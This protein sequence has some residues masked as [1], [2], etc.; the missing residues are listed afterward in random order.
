VYGNDRSSM[1]KVFF[2]AWD[3]YRQSLPLEGIEQRLIEIILQHPEYHTVLE[4]RERYLDHDWSPEQGETNPFMHMSM[5]VSIEEQLATNSPRGIGEHYQR[6]LNSEG[7]RH[8][9]MHSMMDCLAEAIWK[10]QR[11][12]TTNLEETYLECLEKTGQK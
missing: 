1:R 4:N 5:H 11:Y 3:K 12:E 7:D 2:N 10:A 9:A 8:A 6:V